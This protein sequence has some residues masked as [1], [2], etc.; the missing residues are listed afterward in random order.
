MWDGAGRKETKI[1]SI[2]N[3]K[4]GGCFQSPTL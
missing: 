3:K 1:D 4:V 2:K